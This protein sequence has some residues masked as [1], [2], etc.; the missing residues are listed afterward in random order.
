MKVVWSPAADRDLGRRY[1]YLRSR[2]P[3]A[4]RRLARRVLAAVE[5]LVE[6]PDMGPVIPGLQPVGVYRRVVVGPHMLV[7]RHDGRTLFILRF[8]D[9]R[10][11]PASFSLGRHEE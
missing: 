4:A 6:Q 10:Q 8:W 9:A 1:S 7:Y 5:L 2:S 3:D 11:D